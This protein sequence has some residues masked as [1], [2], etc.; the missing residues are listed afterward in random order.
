[1]ISPQHRRSPDPCLVEPVEQRVLLSGWEAHVNFQPNN[2]PKVK[3]YMA[4]VGGVFK[5]RGVVSYGWSEVNTLNAFDRNAKAAKDQRFD[6]LV[7]MQKGRKN[8]RWEIAVPNGQYQVRIVAGDAKDTGNVYKIKAE[9]TVVVNRAIPVGSKS[10]WAAGTAIVTVKDGRL[11]L[12]AAPGAVRNKLCF[13]DIVQVR[14]SAGTF[15]AEAFDATSGA[16][17]SGEVVTS[18]DPGDWIRYD[19][20][21]FTKNFNSIQARLGVA[22]WQAGQDLEFR[23]DSPDGPLL[24]TLSTEGGGDGSAFTTQSTPITTNVTGVH[25]LYVVFKGSQPVGQ[26]DLFRFSGRQ[27]VQVMALGDSI[28]EGRGGHDSYRRSLWKNIENG[29]YSVDFVGNKSGVRPTSGEPTAYDW[30]LDYAAES[31]R[32]ADEI[33]DR[34]PGWLDAS[35]MPD[36]VLIHLGANDL[37]ANQ[38]AASTAGEIGEIIDI[39]RGRNPDVKVVVAKIAYADAQFF[40]NAQVDNLNDAI[41]AMVADKDTAGSPVVTVDQNTGFDPATDTFDGLHPTAA[42]ENVQADRWFAKLKDWL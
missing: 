39:L 1:M 15:G 18:M 14:N 4:D 16:A 17:A 13:V 33:R 7:A 5:K 38:S 30:D 23:V 37:R 26:M 27:F 9:N 34:L 28:T 20:V 25:D 40:S 42:A 19:N 41:V 21:L 29:G 10:R 36:V 6:T 3:G 22:G 35:P 11:S 32:R 24:G 8:L 31:G 2:A 12:A